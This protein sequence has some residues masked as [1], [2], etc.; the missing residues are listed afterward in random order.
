VTEGTVQWVEELIRAERRIMI[1]NVATALG[2][3]HGLAHSIIHL[4]FEITERVFT[5]GT[6][7]TKGLRKKN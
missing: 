7:G 4:S 1:D 6:Y 5:V 3:S 2:C